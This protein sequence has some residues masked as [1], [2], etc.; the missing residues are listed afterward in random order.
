MHRQAGIKRSMSARSLGILLCLALATLG[1]PAEEYLGLYMMGSK[2]GYASYRSSE[3]TFLGEK[4]LRSDSKTLIDSQLLGSALKLTVDST[5]WK[6][7]EG[8]PL[9]MLFVTESG[10]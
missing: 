3:D 2:I 5:T 6:S 8:Q 10:G 1:L 9:K 7:P 4:A